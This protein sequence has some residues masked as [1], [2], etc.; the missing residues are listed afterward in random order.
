MNSVPEWVPLLTDIVGH[1]VTAVEH[2]TPRGV[3]LLLDNGDSVRFVA[4]GDTLVR[5]APPRASH[6]RM[7]VISRWRNWWYRRTVIDPFIREL[8]QIAAEG[9]GVSKCAC[10]RCSP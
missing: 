6:R 4:S 8:H 3:T 9:R 5:I 7:S 1:T 2:V 10:T